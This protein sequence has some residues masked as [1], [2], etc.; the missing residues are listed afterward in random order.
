MGEGS[1]LSRLFAFGLGYSAET[2]ARRLR[3]KGWEIA[4]TARDPANAERL[5]RAGYAVASFAGEANNEAVT[6]LLAG[7]THIVHS[8]P[9]PT[10]GDPVLTR[11]RERL[12]SLPTVEWI[13]YL[14]T[15]G[16]YGDH[17]GAEIDETAALK[18][19]SDRT[20]ARVAAESD[21]L[22]FGQE[23]GVPVQIFRLAGIYGPGRSAFEKLRDGTAR[24]VVKPGQVF[25]RIHVD[26]I[27]AVL[28]ASIAHPRAGGIY[29]VA[30]D[31]PAAPDEVIAFA[32]D[33]AGMDAPPAVPFEEAELSPMAR[34]FYAD[35]RRISN[36]RIKSELGV[37]LAFPTYREGLKSLVQ[38]ARQ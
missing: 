3:D 16:V 27:A 9:P 18:P 2:L 17:A 29:N 19:S 35:S 28:E 1:R 24:R 13:G 23:T 32:A 25:S 34:S 33:L 20:T 38:S 22:A 37:K 36:A 11:Y 7:T 4:G 8:I 31:E 14:S 12:A 15:V 10:S 26:D 5:R 21:W 30:D 6:E